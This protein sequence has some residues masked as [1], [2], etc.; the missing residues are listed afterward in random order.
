MI[1]ER[2]MKHIAG[3]LFLLW[4]ASLLFAQQPSL[5]E[6]EIIEKAQQRFLSETAKEKIFRFTGDTEVAVGDTLKGHVL[7]IHGN[8]KVR[9]VIDGDV[10]VVWGDVSIYNTGRVQGNVTAVGG[11]IHLYGKGQVSGEMLETHVNNLVGKS[12]TVTWYY[13]RSIESDRYGTI[14][15]EHG[16]NHIIFKYNR[17]EGVFLGLNVPKNFIP[18]VGHFSLYGFVGYGFETR[19]GRFQVGLDR[20]FFSP[21]K[22]R[23]E[24][25]G[26]FHDLTDTKDVWRMPYLENTLATLFLREDFHDYFRREGFSFHASQNVTPYLKLTLEYRSDR[27]SSLQKGTDWSIFGGKKKFRPNP[28]LGADEGFM[29]TVYGEVYWDNRDNR[30]N[31]TEGWYV[32]LSGET[33]SSGLGGDFSFE[34]YLLDV[35]RFWPIAR[36]ENFNFRLMAGTSRGH[37][38]FQ[39]NFELGGVSTLRGFRFKEFSGSSMVLGNFEY[40]ISSRLMSG[41][42][43]LCG[44]CFDV[45]LFADVGWAWAAPDS[46]STIERLKMLRWDCLKSDV[47][48]ALGSP[49][50]N[51]RLNIAKRTDRSQDAFV[52]TFRISQPF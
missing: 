41:A 38:P 19:R 28:S 20:W 43:P 34:R 45:I 29:R 7:V 40:R 51:V 21:R 5:Q 15:I 8:L 6:Q 52:V 10:L 47:G 32:R 18:D 14:P 16:G 30:E 33:A 9:G 23:F 13:K 3:I 49:D 22:Y 17:V 12:K 46:T 26:E 25:G 24:L 31:T 39:K 35:R 42:L 11:T 37:L 36:G 44:D 48:F 1:Q 2:P 27:Y 50:D 4:F